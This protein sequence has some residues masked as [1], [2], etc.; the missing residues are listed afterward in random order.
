MAS[1]IG[2]P[3]ISDSRRDAEKYHK[4]LFAI[5]SATNT[6]NSLEKQGRA[7]IDEVLASLLPDLADAL[8]AEQAFVAIYRPGNDLRV[9]AFEIVSVYPKRKKTTG[10]LLPWSKPLGQV[11][12]SQHARVIEPFEDAPRRI[13]PGLELFEATTA[14]LIQMS[15]GSQSRIVGVCNRKNPD[16]GPFLGTDRRALES[17]IELI[18]IGMRV[19]ERR[20][21]ELENIQNISAA[22]NAELNLDELLPLIARL[23]AEVFSVPAA[24]LMLWDKK[25]E[26]LIIEASHG[27]SSQYVKRQRIPRKTVDMELARSENKRAIVTPDLQKSRFGKPN[28]I[29]SENLRSALTAQLQVSGEMM[30]ILNIYSR[31]NERAFTS[32]ELELAEIFANHAAIAIH[33]ARLRQRDL[34]GLLATSDALKATLDENE[35]LELIVVKVHS[36]FSAPV[37][38]MVWDEEKNKL[39]I[40][41]T[42][43]LS[44]NWVGYHV[45]TSD[46]IFAL[47][48][49]KREL[50]PSVVVDLDKAVYGL[51]RLCSQEKLL[52]ALVTPIAMPGASRVM[53]FLLIYGKGEARPFIA[54][55]INIAGI[56]ADQAA[57]AIR[58]TQFHSENKQRGDQLA[59]LDQI[60]LDITGELKLNIQELLTSIIT[61][62]T[63]LVGAKD[64]IIYQWY[65]KEEEIHPV[66]SPAGFN[67]FG[68]KVDKKRGLIGEII[69]T[70]A[71]YVV[72]HYRR[73]SKRQLTLDRLGLTAVLGVPILSHNRLLGIIVVHHDEPGRKFGKDDRELLQRFANHAAVA[74]D[75]ANIYNAEH[76]AKDYLDRLIKSSSDGII[77]LDRNGWITD[78]NEGAERICGYNP[79]EVLNQKTHVYTL[80]GGTRIPRTIYKILLKQERLDN[81]ETVLRAKDGQQI[82]IVLSASL[83]RDKDQNI[84]GSV[85]FFKDL[86]P[87]RITLN[88]FTDIAKAR[89]LDE[90]LNALAKGMVRGTTITFCQILTQAPNESRFIVRAAYAIH[91]DRSLGQ[92]VNWNPEV[93]KIVESDSA[94]V[95]LNLMESD[96][97]KVFRRGDFQNGVAM[98]EYARRMTG[99]ATE[100]QSV[101]ILPLKSNQGVFGSCILGEERNWDRSPFTEEK[102]SLVRSVAD[103]GAELIQRL[104]MYETL[105]LREGL[106]KAGKG[107]TSLSDLSL[108]LNSIAD[109]VREALNCDLVTLYTYEAAKDRVDLPTTSG[110]LFYPEAM[111]ALGYISKK[112]IVWKILELGEPHFANDAAHDPIMLTMANTIQHASQGPFVVREN[113]AS[114]AGIPL[115]MGNDKVGILFASFRIPHP[116]NE[117]EKNDI[118]IFATQ[119]AMAIY[120][121][122]LYAEI[123]KTKDYLL[124]SQAVAWL[125]LYA[126]DL[127]HTIHQK[128]FSLENITSG[129]REWVQRLDPT[130]DGA[131]DVLSTLN[132]L[133]DLSNNIRA[134]KITNQPLELPGD[135]GTWTYTEIDD[136]IRMI[137]E[138]LLQG[139]SEVENEMEL[140]CP[141]V[142]ARIAP[143]GLQVA[144]EKLVNNAVKAMAGSGKIKICTDK[145]ARMVHIRVIDD[146]QGIPEDV[147]PYFLSRVVPRKQKGEGTGTGV[148]IARFVALSHGGDL[149]LVSTSSEG[150]ELRMMLPSVDE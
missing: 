133:D 78:Y 24:S 98:T 123:S 4:L 140:K 138:K 129:L 57:I 68:L 107:I 101:L 14:V 111:H 20:R 148:L 12:S 29:E 23:A 91:R 32:G 95:L 121:A 25:Q 36:V 131:D 112:S 64:G 18:S 93:G 130:P 87:L 65:E 15:I 86:R 22:I 134:V 120:N 79:E 26:N 35:L 139:Y 10:F 89:G 52:N 76:E 58:T 119:A 38:L 34:Q 103:Q 41:A 145:V 74:I 6:I 104:H 110:D 54:E 114:S 3:V 55:D 116:F 126:A 49:E 81:F 82:P 21:Q 113:I 17:I 128:T 88:T 150:T 99:L 105:R 53:G 132:D 63:Q 40:K 127:Q 44:S 43:G 92:P 1:G 137:C 144:M 47:N 109:G 28:L 102:I 5:E 83:L 84:R 62:A 135:T 19:G 67:I 11:L 59:A 16:L 90:G 61:L 149:E 125:G 50:R 118:T 80:Y 146:G 66:A 106:L 13:V 97:P 96:G 77:A 147:Q 30:G 73:W 122:R 69:R 7:S 70:K 51:E 75:N 117:Q 31:N 85:G 136:E 45:K 124:T 94:A 33:N 46:R 37:S 8:D 71:P 72:N 100:P 9:Q 60:A 27:L 142:K 115:I 48:R 108:I 143:E 2:P 141:G 39:V 56:I 42:H